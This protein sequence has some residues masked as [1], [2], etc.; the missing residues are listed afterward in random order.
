MGR[1]FEKNGG[2]EGGV[3]RRQK[4]EGRRQNFNAGA[5]G[6]LGGFLGGGKVASLCFEKDISF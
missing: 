1:G 3:G 4:L 6:G 2:F 5:E